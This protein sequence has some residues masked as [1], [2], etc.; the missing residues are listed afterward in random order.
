MKIHVEIHSIKIFSSTRFSASAVQF[1]W[2][3]LW[4]THNLLKQVSCLRSWFIWYILR[5]YHANHLVYSKDTWYILCKCFNQ[6]I[7]LFVWTKKA[8]SQ[9]CD[10][11]LAKILG[12]AACIWS[13]CHLWFLFTSPIFTFFIL[14]FLLIIYCLSLLHKLPNNHSRT[15]YQ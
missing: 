4:F 7:F 5:I 1:R 12:H 14:I 10:L 13:K 11:A 6:N 9:I 3:C 2:F 8:Q 15:K